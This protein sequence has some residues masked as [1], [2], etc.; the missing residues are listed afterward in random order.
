V[1]VYSDLESPDGLTRQIRAGVEHWID[2]S[3]YSDEG[4]ARRI[5]DDRIDVLVELAGHTAGN[6][7]PL[8]ARR[9]APLQLSYLGYPFSTGLAALDAMVGDAVTTPVA[10]AGIYR[11]QLLRLPHFPFCMQPHSTAPLVAPLPALTNGHLTFGCFNNLA[12]IGRATLTLWAQL[13]HALP[14][15][16]LLLRAVGLND[17]PTRTRLLRC[18]SEQGIA[19]ARLDLLPPIRPISAYLDGYATI[20][21]ALDPLAYNGGTTSFEALWQGVPVLTLPGRGFC[22]RMGAGINATAGLET[23]SARDSEHFLHIARQWNDQR[24]ALAALRAGLRQRLAGTP[25][26]DGARFIP[27]FEAALREAASNGPRAS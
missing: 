17:E 25:L 11:E 1:F 8:L 16:R 20:D 12:K 21:I 14:D 22:A 15:S 5:R 24:E 23:F 9:V 6:R 3:G 4:L 2:V 26:F 10:D 18:M 19:A 27:A 13:L 7:L